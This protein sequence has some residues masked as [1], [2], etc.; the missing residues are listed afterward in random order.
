MRIIAAVVLGALT[1]LASFS[2][3]NAEPLKVRV[4]WVVPRSDWA[5]ILLEKKDLAPHIGQSY[6]PASV[7]YDASTQMIAALAN[8]E[9]DVA[10]LTYSSLPI[11]IENG[12]LGDLRV[13]AGGLQDGL[14]GFYSQEFLVLADGPIKEIEDLKGKTIASVGAGAAVDVAMRGMLRRHELESERDYTVVN[15]SFSDMRKMLVDKKA[16]LVPSV[17][18]FAFDPELRKIA[19]PLFL[20]SDV[21]GETQLIVWVAR[22]RFIDEHRAAMVDFMEDALR[23][24]RW[25]VD[26]ANHKEATEI[27]GRVIKQSPQSCD[28]LFTQQDY[29]N[30]P[31]MRPELA[32]LQKNID[33]VRDLGFVKDDLDVTQYADLS[34]LDEA[35]AR[36]K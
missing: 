12:G 18:P 31:E 7:H 28:W 4:G 3:G 15:A 1:V 19:R 8:G 20:Q 26:P 29:Y 14:P 25:F 30:D 35:D 5:S 34:L 16:D 27:I 33:L 9:L 36:L 24:T 17:P 22:K 6:V 32:A 23:A 2:Q 13:I 21:S 10:E 11:A